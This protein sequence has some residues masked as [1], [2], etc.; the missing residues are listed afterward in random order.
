MWG[1][2]TVDRLNAL[3]E[4]SLTHYDQ[5]KP[6]FRTSSPK[7]HMLQRPLI[8]RWFGVRAG[9]RLWI[10][11]GGAEMLRSSIEGDV[12]RR[13]ETTWGCGW[14]L[15]R[16]RDVRLQDVLRG[17]SSLM[18]LDFRR[19]RKEPIK[20]KTIIEPRMDLLA[21]PPETDSERFRHGSMTSTQI[22]SHEVWGQH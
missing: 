12:S 22:K 15:W 6:S 10:S 16:W 19:N 21:A 4:S 20:L 3:L 18:F 9:P 8:A 1:R 2:V 14:S 7:E 5:R 11:V 17:L 13:D